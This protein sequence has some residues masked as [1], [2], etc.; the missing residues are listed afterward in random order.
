MSNRFLFELGTEEIPASMIQPALQQLLDAFAALFEENE[1]QAEELKAYCT[2]RRLAIIAGGLP[3]RS[4][5]KEDVV[6]GPPKAVAFGSDGLPTQAAEGFARKQGVAVKDLVLLTTNRGE[7]LALQRLVEG[8]PLP[9]ILGRSIPGI[10]ASISWPKNMYWNESRFRFIRPLR[11][12]VCLWNDVE[13]GFEFEGVKSGRTTRGHRLRGEAAIPVKDVGAYLTCLEENFVLADSADRRSRIVEGLEHE[14]GSLKLRQDD[15]LLETVVF[16]NEYPTVLRGGFDE[17]FLQIPEEVLVTV[18]RFH[19]KYFSLVDEEGHLASSFL[20]VANTDG[21]PDGRIRKGHE[22]VLQARLEDAAFFWKTDQKQPLRDRVPHLE[23][24]LFQ[25]RLGSYLGK[26]ERLRSICKALG[27]G[28]DLESAAFLCKADLTTDMVREFPELQGIM[29]GLYACQQGYPEA[30]W[31][32]VYDHYKP[33]ASDDALPTTRTGVLLSIADRIDTIVGCFGVNIIP[34]GSSDPFGLRRQAQGLVSLLL[35]DALEVPVADLIRM[36][37][38]EFSTE[39]PAADVFE[40]VQRFLKKRVDHIFRREGLS[41]DVLRAVLS[42]GLTTVHDAFR[43]AEALAKIK[44]E[45]D[46]EALAIAFKR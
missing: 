7:Y 16:L 11:W 21:D 13:I 22:K 46:F 18:M 33:I 25:E 24:V 12:Y 23:H 32:A 10:I 37:Q 15:E 1:V 20:T 2:P 4:P 3:D 40:D 29:G 27:G 9:D 42:N 26:T 36:A 41:H 34:S 14:A 44:G 31:K 35:R 43:R 38:R 17:S 28:E 5:N 19:Q 39:R 30:V 8:D 6:S 45:P